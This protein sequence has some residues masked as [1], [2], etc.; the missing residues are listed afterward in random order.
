MY[1]ITWSEQAARDFDELLQFI[2]I[3]SPS[4]ARRVATRITKTLGML[5]SFSLGQPIGDG[6]EKLYIPRTSYFVLFRRIENGTISIRAFIHSAR[7][8]QRFDWE[9]F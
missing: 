5:E 6:V 4:N 1:R 9:K 8:W 2:A 7:D 3:E